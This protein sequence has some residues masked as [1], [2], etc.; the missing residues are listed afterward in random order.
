MACIDFTPV[1]TVVD[2][3]TLDDAEIVAGY[4]DF[5]PG[6]PEPGENRGRA[7]WHGWR[8]RKADHERNPDADSMALVDDVMRNGGAMRA[9]GQTG[10]DMRRAA[11]MRRERRG[12]MTDA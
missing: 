11:R 12:G 5:R 1:R 10:P 9:K 2:L 7:Y 4:R 8:N 3:D 6:D